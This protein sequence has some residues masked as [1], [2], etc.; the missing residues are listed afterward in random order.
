MSLFKNSPKS[1]NQIAAF[2]HVTSSTN[3]I[4]C[5]T[6]APLRMSNWKCP[7]AHAQPEVHCNHC[8]MG[9]QMLNIYYLYHLGPVVAAQHIRD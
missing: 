3:Q 9:G 8:G 7:T 1:T 6:H 4:A 5:F 2:G